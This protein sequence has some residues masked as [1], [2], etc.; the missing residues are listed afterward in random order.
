MH[1]LA[2]RVIKRAFLKKK[3]NLHALDHKKPYTFEHMTH[4]YLVI[5]Q[6]PFSKHP[7]ENHRLKL[8]YNM[9]TS[10]QQIN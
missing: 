4:G 10:K 3:N 9:H 5:L 2:T 8:L 1:F 7:W 6:Q